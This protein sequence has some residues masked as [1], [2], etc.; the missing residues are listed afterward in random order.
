MTEFANWSENS[1]KRRCLFV[2]IERET[3]VFHVSVG[4]ESTTRELKIVSFLLK[5]P[6]GG[7]YSYNIEKDNELHLQHTRIQ[8]TTKDV[9]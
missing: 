3:I 6:K 9:D 2:L 1:E 5:Y 8:G 4:L 7:K